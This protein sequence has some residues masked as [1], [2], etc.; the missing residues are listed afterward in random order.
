[1]DEDAREFFERYKDYTIQT[2]IVDPYNADSKLNDTSIRR[3]YEKYGIYVE[4]PTVEKGDYG[5]IPE[6]I[7][8][9]ANN[10]DRLFVNE[11]HCQMFYD[12]I[13]MAHYPERGESSQAVK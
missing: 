10:L 5:N 8:I 4:L 12:I 6:Q 9:T 2:F 3:E 1:M 7:R 11:L 13:A